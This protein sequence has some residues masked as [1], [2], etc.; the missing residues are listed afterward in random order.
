MLRRRW[1]RA[2]SSSAAAMSSSVRTERRSPVRRRIAVAAVAFA[3]FVGGNSLAAHLIPAYASFLSRLPIAGALLNNTGLISA[4][5]VVPAN[6]TSTDHGFT[7]HVVGSYADHSG[8]QVLFTVKG[9]TGEVV[10]DLLGATTTLTDPFG[11]TYTLNPHDL[12]SGDFILAPPWNWSLNFEPLRG[13][14]I[15]S[16][17][18][19][20]MH[21]RG[22]YINAHTDR[23]AS[24]ELRFK[25][26]SCRR[27]PRQLP[28][29]S[30]SAPTTTPSTRS[31]RP[32]PESTSHLLRRATNLHFREPRSPHSRSPPACSALTVLWGIRSSPSTGR[33]GSDTRISKAPG[34]PQPQR[35]PSRPRCLHRMDPAPTGSHSRTSTGR[36]CR[37]PLWSA[38]A[39][40]RVRSSALGCRRVRTSRG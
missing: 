33:M 38:Q 3:V 13:A 10:P 40:D 22:L 6:D 2:F 27:Y 32:T 29:R 14:A 18:S 11:T 20:T 25:V 34:G 35:P 4:T 23:A 16:T 24:W 30:S 7:L 17:V 19:V 28:R 26:G 37:T 31:S 12:G 5:D 15:N 21:I 9:P 39:V 1:L 8:T 36:P